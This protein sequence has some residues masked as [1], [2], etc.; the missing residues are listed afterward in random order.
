MLAG[1]VSVQVVGNTLSI[2]GDRYD[3]FLEVFGTST[4][5]KYVVE[6][7]SN[8]SNSSDPGTRINHVL[9]GSLCF[10]GVTNINVALGAGNDGFGL[11]DANV[12]GNVSVDMSDGCDEVGIGELPVQ[13]SATVSTSS[14]TPLLISSGSADVTICGNLS[15]NLGSGNNEL[16]E[17]S[18]FVKG[19]ETVN[20]C[21]GN[22]SLLFTDNELSLAP[23]V[24]PAVVA[25][26]SVPIGSGVTVNGNL[27]VNLGGG[28]NSFESCDLSV[29]GSFTTTGS[30]SNDLNMLNLTV[31]KDATFT[32]SGCGNDEVIFGCCLDTETPDVAP[33]QAIGQI[34]QANHIGGNLFI[35]TGWGNDLIEETSLSVVLCNTINTGCGSDEVLL[36]T[37]HD[38][39]SPAP[40]AVGPIGFLA[41]NVGK[42]LNV[43][44]GNGCDVID[45]IDVAVCGNF[46]I[47]GGCGSLSADLEDVLV[48]NLL[49]IVNGNGTS[50]VRVADTCA[51]T[52]S[53]STG[54][55]CDNVTLSG[56]TFCTA[57]VGLGGRN[58]TL[59]VTHTT[60]TQSVCFNGGS[61]CNTYNYACNTF[62][63]NLSLVK[64]VNFQTQKSLN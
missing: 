23:G 29:G 54:C 28:C 40:A 56:D 2:I 33:L 1:D 22:D 30:G 63:S 43:N 12:S 20:A 51:K 34:G 61:G 57:T 5:G 53:I 55:G 26:Q 16:F 64:I 52:L 18:L 7:L 13:V 42:D 21:D 44:L 24:T 47:N 36:G 59:T 10:S 3:N 15:L 60:I 11:T 38:N 32:L 31:C 45:A 6:G 58:D 27:L 50:N 39:A 4:P 19:C 62:P 9:N 48:S 8:P 46:N 37:T 17:S 41:V 35:T 49:K 14:I 25:P